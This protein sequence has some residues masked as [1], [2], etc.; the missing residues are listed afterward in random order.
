[1]SKVKLTIA[2]LAAVIALSAVTAVSASADWFVNGA[3]LTTSAALS[4]TAAVD[5]TTKLLVPSVGDLTIECSGTTLDGINPEIKNPDRGFAAAL[6]FLT[7]NTVTPA[8]CELSNPNETIT[9]SEILAR[10]FLGAGEED[11]VLFSPETKATFANIAFAS[12]NTCAFTS[13]QA[14]KGAVTIGAPTGQLEL[15]AQAIVG[16]GSVENNSLEIGSGNKAYLIGG[17][18]LLTLQ[19]GSKWSFK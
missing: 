8:N 5:Q 9:T 7:C 16:L 15:A 18:A 14:V 3:K 12:T 19:S 1:M 2:A 4:T 10:A 17:K 13:T 11:R 6:R